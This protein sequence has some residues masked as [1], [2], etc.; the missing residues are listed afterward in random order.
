MSDKFLPTRTLLYV[1]VRHIFI[2]LISFLVMHGTYNVKLK[3]STNIA[4]VSHHCYFCRSLRLVSVSMYLCL[5]RSSAQQNEANRMD[6]KSDI[7]PFVSRISVLIKD[8]VCFLYV[9]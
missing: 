8:G 9:L 1:S 5:N 2:S 6:M 7:L 3:M 4:Y